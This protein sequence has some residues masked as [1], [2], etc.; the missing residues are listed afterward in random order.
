MFPSIQLRMLGEV[1][2]VLFF[3]YYFQKEARS[4]RHYRP[5]IA[6][7]MD[8]ANVGG[9]VQPTPLSWLPVLLSSLHWSSRSTGCVQCVGFVSPIFCCAAGPVSVPFPFPPSPS[10]LCRSSRHCS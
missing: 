9:D 5:Y 6:Y 1:V 4:L 10:H 3:L 8:F 7:F 2:L